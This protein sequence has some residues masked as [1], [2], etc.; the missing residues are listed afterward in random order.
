MEFRKAYTQM[1]VQLIC[2]EPTLTK[3]SM[4]AEA[5]INNIM[6]KYI[7]TG[8]LEFTNQN[9]ARYDDFSGF[10][11]MNAMNTVAKANE[12]F[13]GL[14]ASMRKRFNNEPGELLAFVNDPRNYDE[15]VRLGILNARPAPVVAPVEP[16]PTPAV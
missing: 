9:Q 13:M 14:P 16:I 5:D 6:A 1:S 8:L 10:D 2:P 15:G 7:R 11:F 12:M 3:Q 4:K